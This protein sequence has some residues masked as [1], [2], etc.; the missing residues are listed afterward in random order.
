LTR[1]AAAN[2]QLAAALQGY[3]DSATMAETS[4]KVQGFQEKVVNAQGAQTALSTKLQC[5]A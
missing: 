4:T 3:P 2:S 5:S 1:L